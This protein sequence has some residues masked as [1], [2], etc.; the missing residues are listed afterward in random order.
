MRTCGFTSIFLLCAFL[1]S[2]C[3]K[4]EV[5]TKLKDP[6]TLRA[7]AM[8]MLD[9]LPLGDV[10]TAAWPNSIKA[11][12]PLSVTRETDN[13]KIL[14]AHEDRRFSVGYHVFRTKSSMPSMRGVWIE[15]T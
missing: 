6:S 1:L 11:L 8:R 14:L 12:K 3:H 4:Q 5:D 13:I 9:N 10:P 15:K 2:A 7:D